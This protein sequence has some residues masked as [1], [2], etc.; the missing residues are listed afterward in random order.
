MKKS[1]QASTGT[2]AKGKTIFLLG[3]HASGSR[4]V[5]YQAVFAR[6]G[7]TAEPVKGYFDY[8]ASR[9]FAAQAVEGW[10]A[11]DGRPPLNGKAFDSRSRHLHC[12]T[13]EP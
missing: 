10:S 11:A 3:A 8:L 13:Q 6:L 7:G 1:A 4:T 12:L 5:R 9:Y 2:G